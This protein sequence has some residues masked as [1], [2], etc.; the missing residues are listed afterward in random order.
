MATVTALDP[1]RAPGADLDLDALL[2]LDPAALSSL[3]ND[4]AVPRVP[5]LSGDLRGRMLA[6]QGVTGLPA[7]ALRALAGS[8]AFPWRGK[9]FA[10]EG[11]DA[12]HGKNRVVSDRVRLFRF[13]TC[14]GPSRAGDFDAVQL[15]YDH[16][17]NP[18]LIRAVKD[19]VREL[20]SGLWL[21]Q[22]WWQ[23]SAASRPRLVL[24]F[25]LA[26]R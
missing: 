26:A 7:R 18:R 19:E 4:A 1:T 14:V 21:G 15:D 17:D 3:Y 20:R 8:A 22:A 13:T 16:R 9:S 24:W 11:P 10:H 2:A 12:G 6:W 25:G 5:D 23:W